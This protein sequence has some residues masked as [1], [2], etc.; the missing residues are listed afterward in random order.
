MPVVHLLWLATAAQNSS[1]PFWFFFDKIKRLLWL[2][3]PFCYLQLKHSNMT[4][5]V[6]DF[7]TLGNNIS[8]ETFI[9]H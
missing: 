6:C 7:Y 2:Q 9:K 4:S 3:G 5:R 1:M 8:A